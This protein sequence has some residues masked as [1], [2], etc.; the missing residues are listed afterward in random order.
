MRW[1]QL[2]NYKYG[3]ILMWRKGCYN[4]FL[5]SQI[6]CEQNFT[7]ISRSVQKTQKN[8]KASQTGQFETED[9][10]TEKTQ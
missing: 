2:H 6:K 7:L 10:E 9:I 1:M 8:E 3:K 4:Q 5:H